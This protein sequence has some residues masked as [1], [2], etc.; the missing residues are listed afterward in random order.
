MNEKI[1]VM[2]DDDPEDCELTAEA[3]RA[4]DLDIPL[5]FVHDGI[6]LMDFLKRRNQ[7]EDVDDMPLPALILLDLNM[8]RMGGHAVLEMIKHDRELSKIPIVVL[9]TS[10]NLDDVE[11][12]YRLGAQSYLIKPHSFADLVEKVRELNHYWFETVQLP[13]EA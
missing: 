1:I 7:F 6:E 10:S 5:I 12:T 9:T 4:A 13:T 3:L 11:R 8:P 2:A